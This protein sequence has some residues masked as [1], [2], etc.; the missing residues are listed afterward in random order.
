MP[1]RIVIV[2]SNPSLTEQARQAFTGAGHD[3]AVFTNPLKGLDALER[4][5]RIELLIT[6]IDFGPGRLNGAAL[7]RMARFKKPGVRVLLMGQMEERQY[8]EKELGEFL[9]RPV[10]VVTLLDAAA[11][12]LRAAPATGTPDQ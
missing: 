4:A 3:V 11:R 9:P 7:A 5:N 12:L 1:A 10:A 8:V 2:G 6:D